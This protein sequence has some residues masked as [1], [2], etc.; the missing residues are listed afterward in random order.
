MGQK[1]WYHLPLILHALEN[2]PQWQQVLFLSL[3]PKTR[4]SRRFWEMKLKIKKTEKKKQYISTTTAIFVCF[5]KVNHFFPT[6]PK[7]T[8]LF[9]MSQKKHEI[10][11]NIESQ[12]MIEFNY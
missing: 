6:S 12:F 1:N 9:K 11:K 2:S 8:N 10:N 3:P 5:W 4:P 7:N